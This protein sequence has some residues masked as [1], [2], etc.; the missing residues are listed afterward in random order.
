VLVPQYET[1]LYSGNYAVLVI[2]ATSVDMPNL[3]NEHAISSVSESEY[4]DA[5]G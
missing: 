4:L 2:V 3:K 1:K 5:M